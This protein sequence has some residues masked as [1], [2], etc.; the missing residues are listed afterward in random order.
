MKKLF[1]ALLL[2]A[3]LAF[4]VVNI[5]TASKE[6]LMSIKGIGETRAEAIIKQREAAPFK[7]IED[8]KSVKGIGDGIFEQIKDEISVA[9]KSEPASNLAKKDAK[10]ELKSDS[11]KD[12]K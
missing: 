6:E 3:S 10:S 8:I 1:C 4:G 11:K 9:G 2:S 5:N 12:K 7:N